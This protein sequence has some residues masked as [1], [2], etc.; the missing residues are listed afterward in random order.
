MMVLMA[1]AMFGWNLPGGTG[2]LLLDVSDFSCAPDGGASLGPCNASSQPTNYTLWR[3]STTGS[4][5]VSMAITNN[6]GRPGAPSSVSFGVQ[7]C[8]PPNPNP[9][10]LGCYR[11]ELALQRKY[12]DNLIDW[13]TG[14][15]SSERWW[16]FAN[17]L[18]RNLT[19]DG[20]GPMALMGPSFQIHGGGGLPSL[21]ALHPCFNLQLC[22]A[23]VLFAGGTTAAHIQMP[24]QPIELHVPPL[25]SRY[26]ATPLQSDPHS[27][28][29]VF[30][31][32]P[33]ALGA[34]DDWVIRARLSPRPD[35]GYVQVW[36]NG[37]CLVPTTTLATAYNDTIAP[38][39]KFGVYKGSW[40]GASKPVEKWAGIEYLA[41]KFLIMGLECNLLA[42]LKSNHKIPELLRNSAAH[43]SAS[44]LTWS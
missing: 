6:T 8:E 43:H 44:A 25:D 41:M 29:T 40:K 22:K 16:G 35:T 34:W 3:W 17:R 14:L 39:L 33:V 32:G 12:Q 18:P 20:S 15:G 23:C 26:P 28:A 31:L 7:Y 4:A 27:D 9:N 19:W 5:Q 1:L 11:S 13:K 37:N 21:K 38:Y 42:H 36:R 10:L 2:R 24:E 30:D